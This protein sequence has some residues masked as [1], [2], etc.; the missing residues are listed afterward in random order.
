VRFFFAEVLFHHEY[1]LAVGSNHS[2]AAAMQSKRSLNSF[3]SSE[4]LDQ[5]TCT[6][7]LLLASLQPGVQSEDGPSLACTAGPKPQ[8][9][10]EEHEY[11]VKRS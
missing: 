10:D 11:K 5:E 9:I 2:P 8:Y 6:G 4:S 3:L 1:T 7:Y